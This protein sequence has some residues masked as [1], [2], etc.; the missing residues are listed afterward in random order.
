[1]NFVLRSGTVLSTFIPFNSVE[2]AVYVVSD[3]HFGCD[4]RWSSRIREGIFL[5]FLDE[6]LPSCRELILLGDLFDFWF[7]Y[8]RAIPRRHADFLCE[9]RNRVGHTPVCVFYGNHDA[10]YRDFLVEFLGAEIV[11]EPQVRTLFQR[12]Y[13]LAHG[14][15]LG[16]GD[17]G[18]KFLKSV[19]RSRWFYRFFRAIH[20]DYALAAADAVSET[21][22]NAAE[23]ENVNFLAPNHPL[24]RYADSRFDT[25]PDLHAVVFGHLHCLKR[26]E[27][28]NKTLFFLGDWIKYFSFLKITEQGE[29]LCQYTGP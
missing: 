13:L 21:R 1:M 15:G 23:M 2:K 7:E 29:T 9:F 14:D 28:R 26:M 27:R 25:D 8:R 5:R 22:R 24:I 6:I 20:P 11:P 4:T 17:Y 19:L 18:Y 12:R 16:K 10:W 3:L